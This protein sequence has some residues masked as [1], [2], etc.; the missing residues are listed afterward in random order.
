M[1]ADPTHL[2]TFLSFI[3]ALTLALIHVGA[4][5]AHH[6]GELRPRWLSAA[7]GISVAYVLVDLLPELSEAQALWLEARPERP[8]WWLERQ[9]Y[10]MALLGL[11]LALGLERM[12]SS[13]GDRREAR[14]WLHTSSF[15]VY[16][17]LIGGFALRVSGVISLIFA[18]LAF[19]GH[20]LVND[21]S[22]RRAYGR[23]YEG[24]GR[25][26]LAGSILLGWFVEMLWRV[27]V[28]IAMALLGLVAGGIILN[29]I[30]EEL[31]E[32]KEGAF[33]VFVAGAA[34]YTSVLL[35]FAYSQSSG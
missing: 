9:I 33:S 26:L 35:A 4:G 27:P 21:H 1:A 3:A 32:D 15:A 16:N 34:I 19:G 5:W 18:L 6:G 25:W 10:V 7:S 30:K 14:F 12:T 2:R 31:P 8:L 22:L 28:E 23:A 29:V 11:V 13:R 24:T 20:F 17:F